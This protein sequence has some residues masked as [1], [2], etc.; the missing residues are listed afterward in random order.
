MPTPPTIN[1]LTII[2]SKIHRPGDEEEVDHAQEQL[3]DTETE[4]EGQ[5]SSLRRSGARGRSR[6]SSSSVVPPDIFQIILERI[7]GL[8]EV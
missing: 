4:V 3:M 8:R 6:F 1:A 2:R 5:P 7:D